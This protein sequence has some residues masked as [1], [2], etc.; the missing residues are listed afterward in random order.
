MEK[1]I[2]KINFDVN[3]LI[4]KYKHIIKMIEYSIFDN[5]HILEI[6]VNDSNEIINCATKMLKY[7]I[8]KKF[9]KK[10]SFCFQIE[11]IS[12]K[13][14]NKIGEL[15]KLDDNICVTLMTNI[16]QMKDSFSEIMKRYY[17]CNN[18]V[19]LIFICNITG[20]E[21]FYMLGYERSM[22]Y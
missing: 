15:G 8:I 1:K 12:S 5:V 4:I 16:S 2:K 9:E 22:F 18:R 19:D 14:I 11:S 10:K 6:K 13:I 21:I 7:N 20:D 3:K 17:L